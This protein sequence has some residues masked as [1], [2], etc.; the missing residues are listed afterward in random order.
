MNAPT[1]FISHC[2]AAFDR[3]IPVNVRS[4]PKELRAARHLTLLAAITAVSVPL[5]T[6]MYHF[7]GYDSAGMVVLTGGIV[8]MIAPFAMNAGLRLPLARD[9]FIGALFLLKI[10][11]AVHLGG[12]SAPTV[13]WFL[14]CPLIAVLLGGLLPG[15]VWSALVS[16]AILALFAVEQTSGQFIAHPVSNQQVLQLVSLIGLFALSTIIALCFR[17]D[18]EY[19]L[20]AASAN[21]A[22]R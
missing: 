19:A 18:F 1:S 10:W 9:L 3:V 14:L 5:L 20:N 17:A 8:M 2:L 16:T 13:P 21:P 22:N 12:L 6:L 11:L 15:L 4:N 7:L